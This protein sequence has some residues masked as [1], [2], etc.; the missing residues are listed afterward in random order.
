M[1]SV[2]TKYKPNQRSLI[3]EETSKIFDIA[4]QNSAHDGALTPMINYDD[5]NSAGALR[6]STNDSM[7][8]PGTVN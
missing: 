7:D 2:H 8:E 4:M 1:A 3:I 5:N 6:L